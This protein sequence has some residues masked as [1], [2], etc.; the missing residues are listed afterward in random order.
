MYTL[1]RFAHYA[2]PDHKPG[3]PGSVSEGPS[4]SLGVAVGRWCVP[5]HPWRF[6]GGSLALLGPLGY[7]WDVVGG[8]RAWDVVG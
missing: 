4:G 5:G 7:P 6:L 1:N 3:K 2:W 8:L